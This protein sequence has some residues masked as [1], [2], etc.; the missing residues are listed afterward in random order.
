MHENNTTVFNTTSNN[1]LLC[2]VV[3]KFIAMIIGVLGNVTV[4]IYYYILVIITIFFNKEK[5]ATSHL[6]GN[7]AAADLLVCLTFYPIWII[8]LIQ[9]ALN[10]ESDQD[11][12]CKFSTSIQCGHLCLL[13]LL[14]FL[15]LQSTVIYI[16]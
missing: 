1:V 13:Q 7:L 14:H 9:T 16:L 8:V 5:T 11:L 6:V 3:F 2:S 12:F 4:I 10:I 15:Q